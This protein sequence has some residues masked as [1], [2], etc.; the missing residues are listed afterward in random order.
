MLKAVTGRASTTTI[1]NPDGT[2]TVVTTTYKLDGTKAT[3]RK[4]T[5][6]KRTS[7]SKSVTL[8]PSNS[9]SK[10]APL[11]PSNDSR[12]RMPP[13][14]SSSMPMMRNSSCRFLVAEL[15]EEVKQELKKVLGVGHADNPAFASEVSRA[16]PAEIVLI[17]SQDDVTQAQEGDSAVRKYGLPKIPNTRSNYGSLATCAL[18]QMLYECPDRVMAGSSAPPYDCRELIKEIQQRVKKCSSLHEAN[19]VL[20]SSRPLGPPAIKGGKYAPFY[21]VPPGF[22]GKRRA[23]LICVVTGEGDDL[24]GPPND[25]QYMYHFLTENCGFQDK[26]VVVLRDDAHAPEGSKKSTKQNILDG[27]AQIVQQSKKNDVAFIQFSGHGGRM[28]DSLYI[29]PSDY[30][31]RGQIMD[32]EILKDLIKYMPANVHTT[33]LVDCCY[34]GVIGDLPYSLQS[35]EGAPEQQEIESY[36]DTD[37]RQEMMENEERGDMEYQKKKQARSK[38]RN[39]NRIATAAKAYAKEMAKDLGKAAEAAGSAAM[40]A[41]DTGSNHVRNSLE[42]AGK[43]TKQDLDKSSDHLSSSLHG[44]DNAKVESPRTVIP[45]KSPVPRASATLVQKIPRPRSNGDLETAMR[46][47]SKSESKEGTAAL[48]RG[49]MPPR[50]AKSSVNAATEREAKERTT[51]VENSAKE[52]TAGTKATTRTI[53]AR[54]KSTGGTTTKADASLSKPR[55]PPPNK[56]VPMRSKS[57]E[58]L[59]K[60][61]ELIARKEAVERSKREAAEARAAAKKTME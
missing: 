1:E 48:R 23:L 53:P 58:D 39:V 20:S 54:S 3:R 42:G 44:N 55:A 17:A 38:W 41:L 26:D 31:E 22:T 14:R 50:R 13:K 59:A 18:L 47:A 19:P 45:P 2:V 46:K 37:T 60:E 29:L 7:S 34:S 10:C 15:V 5:S 6:P 35:K 8:E 52:A 49:I 4:T 9:A 40:S 36:Y 28:G 25:I 24:K 51:S 11:L 61:R 30:K 32:D 43:P 16:I 21:I 56:K 12:S 33:M 57:V 27:F